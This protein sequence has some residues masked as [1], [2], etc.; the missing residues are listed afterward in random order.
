M[1]WQPKML[2][3]SCL[4]TQ[5][6]ATADGPYEML[7]LDALTARYGMICFLKLDVEAFEASV[8]AGAERVLSVDRPH[9]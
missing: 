5:L 3:K 2:S 9:I 7:T 6:K 8:L 1:D 4:A